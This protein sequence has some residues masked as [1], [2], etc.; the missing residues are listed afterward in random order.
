[1]ASSLLYLRV[2]RPETFE[3]Y[4]QY[5]AQIALSRKRKDIGLRTGC[6]YSKFF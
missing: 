2:Q 6:L 5:K 3:Y 4:N 1:M